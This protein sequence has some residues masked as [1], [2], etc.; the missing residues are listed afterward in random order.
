MGVAQEPPAIVV[1]VVAFGLAV[2]L[3]LV[4][5]WA[6]TVIIKRR[7]QV[8]VDYVSALALSPSAA[9]EELREKIVSL[10]TLASAGAD[11]GQALHN[12]R[13]FVR[14]LR[15]GRPDLSASLAAWQERLDAG[16]S[17][18]E[19]FLVTLMEFQRWTSEE[20]K[21]LAGE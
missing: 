7:R 11:A 21:R 18:A 3:S 5:S 15:G 17:D 20:I 6:L 4:F 13:V 12:L 9:L 1:Y 19:A 14:E 16:V 2:L 10:Q 8:E